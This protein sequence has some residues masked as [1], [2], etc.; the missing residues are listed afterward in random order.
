MSRPHSPTPSSSS[1][2]TRSVIVSALAL[3]SIASLA[4]GCGGSV[5]GGTK[6]DTAPS[7]PAGSSG[8]S[9]GGSRSGCTGDRG[10]CKVGD[11]E[12]SSIAQ[13]PPNATCYDVKL[14]E[15]TLHCIHREACVGGAPACGPGYD[16][17]PKCEPNSMCVVHTTC[18]VTTYCEVQCDGYP[19]CNPNDT[20][21]ASQSACP[22]DASCYPR[23][24]CG[25]TIWCSG[26]G[27]SDAG[28][29]H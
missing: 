13:C 29:P 14:C 19:A 21:V 17:V 27:G 5:D 6:S 24:T 16:P 12:L 18:G 22:K 4:V 15:E 11:E 7:S 28:A 1:F 2:A 8:S 25:I 20:K 10:S 3:A 9:G 23:T 26:A